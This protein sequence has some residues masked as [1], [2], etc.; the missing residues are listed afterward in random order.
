MKNGTRHSLARI[1][2]R[3]MIR[4]CFK[5]KTGIIFDAHMVKN[6]VGLV[7]EPNLTVP[8][9]GSH[10]SIGKKLAVEEHKSLWRRLKEAYNWIM[11]KKE[12]SKKEDSSLKGFISNTEPEEELGD[13]LSPIYDQFDRGLRWKF[14]DYFIP[15]ESSPSNR[16]R[17]LQ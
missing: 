9:L 12:D 10:S 4:E 17:R 11:P 13:A 15:C 16:S 3:W 6:E 5:V 2:L 8:I 14:M 1:P 7:I